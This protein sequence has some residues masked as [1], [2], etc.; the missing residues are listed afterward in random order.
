M[1]KYTIDIERN[2]RMRIKVMYYSKRG[3]TKKVATA[4]AKEFNLP[5]EP[6]PPAYLPENVKLLFLGTGAYGGKIDKKM[7]DFI[8]MLN[9]KRVK[10]VA[11][12]GT[13]AGNNKIME[14]MKELI[15]VQGINVLEQTYLC[16]GKSFIL[17]N[18]KHPTSGELASAG[19]FAR[20]T[21]EALEN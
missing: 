21:A 9:P 19:S 17:M 7:E 13:C 8:S 4:I 15:E 12:F 1:T 3:N 10:N 16:K 20:N 14:R 18:L 5:S 11:L 2:Q 6:I